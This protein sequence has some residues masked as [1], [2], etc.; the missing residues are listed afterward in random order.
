MKLNTRHCLSE[1]HEITRQCVVL[2]GTAWHEKAHRPTSQCMHVTGSSKL[3]HGTCILPASVDREGTA[4]KAAL[5][6]KAESGGAAET[7]TPLLLPLPAA[8]RKLPAGGSCVPITGCCSNCCCPICC[9]WNA[10]GWP[11]NGGC[12]RPDITSAGNGAGPAAAAAAGAAGR[13][14][15]EAGGS[16]SA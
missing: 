9:G 10:T 4:G 15:A 11:C 8:S 7:C 5:A 2:Q 14:C 3:Q 1:H 13:R 6:A 12:A 16:V